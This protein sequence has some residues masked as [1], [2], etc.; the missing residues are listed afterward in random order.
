MNTQNINKWHMCS[1]KINIETIDSFREKGYSL[2]RNFYPNQVVH[3]LKEKI[4]EIAITHPEYCLYDQSTLS[5]EILLHRIYSPIYINNQIGDLLDISKLQFIIENI[6]SEKVSLL[7]DKVNLKL[8][9][10]KGFPPHQD[11][12]G[13][14]KKYVDNIV[15]AFICLDDSNE[16]NG[17][18][19]IA[20]G[21]HKIGLFEVENRSIPE[22]DLK[23]MKFEKITQNAG[24]ILLFDGFV[25]H[26]SGANHSNS[27][28][29][30]IVLT[31]NKEKTG[32]FRDLY[33]YEGF[34]MKYE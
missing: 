26:K 27:S 6:C 34:R 9:G 10:G 25:P 4:L 7:T 28:R 15:T 13:S 17:C 29:I 1:P 33:F 11:M 23:F 8:P 24:D 31:F 3:I 14:F 19:E 16:Q 20:G 21:L 12:Q 2:L 22:K 18:L 5:N 32:N 30:C